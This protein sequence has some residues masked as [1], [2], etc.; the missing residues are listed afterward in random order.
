M[1]MKRLF[2]IDLKDYNPEW[3]HSTRPSVRAIIMRDGKLAL[4]H[5]GK[6]DYYMFPGGGIEAGETH[7]EAL[8]R[9]VKEESGLVVIPESIKEYGSALRLSKS[10][11]FENTIFEQENYYYRCEVQE[12]LDETEF[13]IHEIEEQYSLVYLTPEE[14]VRRNRSNDHGDENGGVWIERETRMMELLINEGSMNRLFTLDAKNYDPAWPHFVRP[15]VR[16]IIVRD[17]KLALVHNGKF[18]YYRFPGGGIEEGETK[19]EALIREVK[20]ESGLVVIPESIKEYGS[21]LRISKIRGGENIIFEQENFYYICEVQEEISTTEFDEHESE[22]QYSLAF[23]TPEDAA[24]RNRIND[25]GEENGS[26]AIERETRII[27][28]L[29]EENQ[30]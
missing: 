18:D 3:P 8:I 15:S 14:A 11:H 17:G 27:E 5:N 19:E 16:G 1:S 13:D 4:V 25:H 12:E 9:E 24:E 28:L 10:S 2:T 23:V 7:E 30:K 26:V 6:F 29:L 20:E 21:V 22:E